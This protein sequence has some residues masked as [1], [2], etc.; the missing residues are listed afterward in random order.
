MRRKRSLMLEISDLP[1]GV[2]LQGTTRT[3]SLSPSVL[4]YLASRGTEIFLLSSLASSGEINTATQK[5]NV[6]NVMIS[7]LYV[8]LTFYIKVFQASI[9][10]IRHCKRLYR[11]I[12]LVRTASLIL[13][14]N[15]GKKIFANL[16]SKAFI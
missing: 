12:F 5:I 16:Q 1:K 4:P 2:I 13:G 6:L 11:Y 3:A 10:T 8:K 15:A 9:W 14:P 7:Q